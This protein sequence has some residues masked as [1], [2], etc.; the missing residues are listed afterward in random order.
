[1]RTKSYEVPADLMPDFAKIVEEW[2]IACSVIGVNEDEMVILEV[3][4]EPE[5]KEAIHE[6]ADLIEE[7]WE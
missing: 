5:E 2:D 1:M 7:Y 6:L 4:Y 3:D